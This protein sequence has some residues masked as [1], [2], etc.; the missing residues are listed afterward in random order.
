MTLTIVATPGD[1]NANSFVTEAE[2]IAYMAARLNATAWTTVSGTTCTETEKSALIEATRELSMMNWC[3]RRVTTTQALGWPRAFAIDPDSPWQFF[4]DQTAVPTRIKNATCELAFQFL[5]AGTT[6]VAS[7]DPTITI[8]SKK[9]G[10]LETEYAEP[11][12]RPKGLR[13]FPRIWNWI[14]PLLNDA[15]GASVALLRG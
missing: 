4:F 3:G 13:R 15:T 6:D 12:N 2:V 7:L 10:P 9:T 14:A 8:V 5:N 1:A 11:Y